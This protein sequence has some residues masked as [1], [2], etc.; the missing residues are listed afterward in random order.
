MFDIK[1]FGERLRAAREQKKI[2]QK[3]VAELLGVTR[4]QISDI[5]NGKTGTSM[6]RLVTLAEFYHVSTDYLLGI[7]DDPVWRGK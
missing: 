6:A 7:T 3:S 5:E 2:S 4:T 1:I